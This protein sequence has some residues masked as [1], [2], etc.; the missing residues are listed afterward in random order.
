MATLTF[1]EK[2]NNS[3]DPVKFGSI[4]SIDSEKLIETST[5]S[6]Y[7][8]KGFKNETLFLS[9]RNSG[10]GG[11]GDICKIDEDCELEVNSN[12]FS[13]IQVLAEKADAIIK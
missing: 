1:K 4:I 9:Q 11:S 5:N 6:L 10:S 2:I 8:R 13:R 12:L 7:I 3:G